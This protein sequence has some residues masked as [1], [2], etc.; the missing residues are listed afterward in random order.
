MSGTA[1]VLLLGE[2]PTPNLLPTRW[3]RPDAAVL[4]YTD[5]TERVAENLRGLLQPVCREIRLC[6][7]TP[8]DIVGCQ[9]SLQTFLSENLPGY[10]FIFNL[11]GGTKL[12]ALTALGLARRYHAPFVYFQTEGNR[13]RLYHYVQENDEIR[14]QKAEDLNVTITLGDYLRMHLGAYES[15]KPRN[16][17]EQQVFQTLQSHS[18]LEILWS[19]RPKGLDA[20]EIDFI[21][22]LGN[23]VGVGEVKTKGAKSGIDQINAVAEQRYLGTYV[24][25]FLI[26]GRQVDRNNKNLAR[27][28][29]IEII[30]L[31]SFAESQMLSQEDRQHLIETIVSRLGGT[32]GKT[33]A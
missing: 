26:S 7:V 1:I 21:V 11:T 30:E 14:Q 17:F 3:L 25:K 22:R 2:Q 24:K 12:M 28:Y 29:R 31:P 33:S 8:Y 19:V 13:S 15:D 32:P 6:K 27:A 10:D 20:L 4:V 23:Q 5:R 18:E 16:D 9:Q